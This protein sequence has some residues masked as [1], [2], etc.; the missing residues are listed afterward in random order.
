MEFNCQNCDRELDEDMNDCPYC[1]EH[2]DKEYKKEILSRKRKKHRAE[3]KKQADENEREEQ[4]LDAIYENDE[5]KIRSMLNGNENG[6]AKSKRK[7]KALI[8]AVKEGNLKMVKLLIEEG[9]DLDITDGD[10]WTALMHATEKGYVPI[11][12]MLIDEGANVSI[13]IGEDYKDIKAEIGRV[14]K[15]MWT[16]PGSQSRADKQRSHDKRRRFLGEK[17]HSNVYIRPKKGWTALK[18][19]DNEYWREDRDEHYEIKRM[20]K[21]ERP[22][23]TAA[24][25]AGN[26]TLGIFFALVGLGYLLRTN[27]S[28]SDWFFRLVGLKK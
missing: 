26:V 27:A 23:G 11:V 25:R 17:G 20:I 22:C 4:F 18:I 19:A 12:E 3:S 28:F 2:V 10:G 5:N 16:L 8:G 21:R 1:G 9:V 24:D 7:T 14:L 6:N 13:R 15:L